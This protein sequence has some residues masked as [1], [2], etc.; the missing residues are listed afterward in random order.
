MCF[1]GKQC[2]IVEGAQ[3]VPARPG[4]RGQ[5]P[6]PGTRSSAVGRAGGRERQE[7]GEVIT[8]RDQRLSRLS[9]AVRPRGLVGV[10]HRCR[11][12]S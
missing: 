2:Y 12:G 8:P 1:P 6:R 3:P 5:D 11:A 4:P 7:S 9:S 10:A